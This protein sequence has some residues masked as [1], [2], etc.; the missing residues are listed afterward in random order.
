MIEQLLPAGV[1]VVE[2]FRRRH[3]DGLVFILLC[4][5]CSTTMRQR[6][7]VLRCSPE[8]CCRLEPNNNVVYITM[9]V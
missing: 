8:I 6:R 5:D 3:A 1:A 2:A 9:L 4:T 7:A